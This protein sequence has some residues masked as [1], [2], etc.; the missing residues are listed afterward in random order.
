MESIQ[1][2]IIYKYADEDSFKQ[3]LLINSQFLMHVL[4][5]YYAYIVFVY[6]YSS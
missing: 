5:E 4:K 1:K 6:M 3:F 2:C